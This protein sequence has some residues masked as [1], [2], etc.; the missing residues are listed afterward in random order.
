VA[1]KDM[2]DARRPRRIGFV[3]PLAL[4]GTRTGHA[5]RLAHEQPVAFGGQGN[6]EVGAAVAVLVA[7]G[8]ESRET[9]RRDLAGGKP[10]VAD[11]AESVEPPAAL[12]D[13]KRVVGGG[14]H[15]AEAVGPVGV[16][17]AQLGRL[18]PLAA[19]PAVDVDGA[20]P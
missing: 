17:G 3:P 19:A 1:A 6:A 7:P 20:R 5:A 9:F 4:P 13:E 11:T 14:E 15:G 16:G 2:D 8:I 18:P 10:V 12:R